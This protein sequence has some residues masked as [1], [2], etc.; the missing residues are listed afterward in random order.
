MSLSRPPTSNIQDRV[1]LGEDACI[2]EP[3]NATDDLQRAL[4][5]E[6]VVLY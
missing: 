5:I 3:I 1:M 2:E 4:I 6:T